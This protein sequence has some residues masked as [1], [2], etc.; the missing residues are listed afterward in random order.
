MYNSGSS[1]GN[2]KNADNIIEEKNDFGEKKVRFVPVAAYREFSS[3]VDTLRNQQ[4]R[5]F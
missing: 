5:Y 3:R 2:F 4:V 1:G